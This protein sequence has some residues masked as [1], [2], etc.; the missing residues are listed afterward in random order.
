MSFTTNPRAGAVAQ[1]QISTSTQVHPD[2][3]YWSPVWATIRDA[4]MG[5]VQIKAKG[6]K[7]LPKL[8]GHD[9]EQYRAF[10]GRAV[11]YNMTAKTLNAL[12]GSLFKRAPVVAGFQPKGRFSKDGQ[13]LNLTAKTAAKEV[14]ATG[15]FGMLVDAASDGRGDPYVA[16]YTAENILDWEMAEVDGEFQLIRVVLREMEF[17]R[18]EGASPQQTDTRFRVLS[19]QPSPTGWQY[20]VDVFHDTNGTGMPDLRGLPDESYVPT[21][22]G[23]SLSKIPFVVVGPFSNTP[24]VAKPPLLDIVTLN[25]SHYLSYAALEQGRFYTANPVYTVSSGTADDTSGEYYVGPDVVWELG[26]D[27]KAEILEFRGAGLQSLENAL[28]K[29]EEQ[30][31]SI[32]G[33]MLAP[34]TGPGES[35]GALKMREANEQSLLLN[36]ADCLDE[37][38]MQV[39]RWLGDWSNAPR[40]QIA[41]T[42]FELA[43][44]FQTKQAG[45]RELRAIHQMYEAGII[46]ID[47]VYEYLRK[48]DVIPDWLSF[49]EFRPMLDD[50]KKFPNMANVLARMRGFPDAAAWA[51]QRRAA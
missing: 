51:E 9:A 15:R 12:Y 34:N 1:I 35:D 26:K 27:G 36:L 6:Q 17:D 21:V 28:A 45:A 2:Y 32:G 10:L 33:R 49:E 20:A 44:D 7:Y 37:A 19:L 23:R 14:L 16:T 41:E 46:P 42:T 24:D 8:A 29:K 25:Y 48:A 39:L 4:E 47:V 22:R 30:I 43:R 40:A 50:E 5:E 11:F 3:L 38:F 18:S 31:A 13:T